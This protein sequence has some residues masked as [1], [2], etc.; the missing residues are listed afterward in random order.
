MLPNYSWIWGLTWSVVTKRTDFPSTGNSET[1]LSEM[2]LL[3]I[4]LTSILGFCLAWTCTCCHNSCEFIC[5]SVLLCLESTVFLKL[6]TISVLYSRPAHLSP[7]LSEPWR[8]GIQLQ[9]CHWAFQ[10]LLFCASCPVVNTFL[11]LH[12]LV[13][14]M[15]SMF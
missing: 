3:L 12:N 10:S 13:F 8:E 6:A 4:S 5:T 7:S 2:I 9:T 15:Q 11:I 14:S 1:L